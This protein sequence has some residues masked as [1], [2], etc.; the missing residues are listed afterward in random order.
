LGALRATGLLDS[1]PEESFDRFTR[2]AARVL[3]APVAFMSLVDDK[4][5]FL[6]SV[7]GLPKALASQREIPLA[8]SLCQLVVT[9]RE[10]VII[11]DTSRHPLVCSNPAF[12]D[13]DVRAYAGVPLSTSVGHVL[14]ALCVI[15]STP[16]A[17]TTHELEV[18]REIAAGIMSEIGLR[19]KTIVKVSQRTSKTAKL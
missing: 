14:G 5:Q 3:Y 13:L 8:H 2:L 10:A 6:K 15:E 9:T 12:S 7:I 1:D 19:S 16:R 18:L 4:R 17:W 11:P